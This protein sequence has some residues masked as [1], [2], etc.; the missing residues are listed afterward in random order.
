MLL[1][2][3]ARLDGPHPRALNSSPSSVLLSP[4]R[5]HLVRNH[6]ANGGVPFLAA[7]SLPCSLRSQNNSIQHF[8]NF[9][10]STF[11]F[12]PAAICGSLALTFAFPACLHGALLHIRVFL[13][14]RPEIDCER[15]SAPPAPM[16]SWIRPV[17][18][19][20]CV[21]WCAPASSGISH[22]TLEPPPLCNHLPWTPLAAPYSSQMFSGCPGIAR[23]GTSTSLRPV[24]TTQSHPPNAQ[25]CVP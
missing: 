25:V 16:T 17:Q 11:Q 7:V 10:W 19:P 18:T 20:K 23:M 5:A 21:F 12:L 13:P 9:L 14:A 1:K 22:R 24:H 4:I 15:V 3:H 2:E 6:V 8:S